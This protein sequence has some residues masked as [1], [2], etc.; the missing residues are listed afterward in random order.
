L[1]E[2]KQTERTMEKQIEQINEL[3]AANQ[4]EKDRTPYLD[5]ALGGLRTALDNYKSHLAVPTKPESAPAQN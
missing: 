4:A 1:I 3:I 2:T 5:M